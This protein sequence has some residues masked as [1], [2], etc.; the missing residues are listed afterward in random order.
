MT[1]FYGDFDK[2]KQEAESLKTFATALELGVN[3]MD[4]AWI[5]QSAGPDGKTYYNEE[6]VGKAIKIHGRDKFIICTKFGISA[7]RGVSDTL[8]SFNL[9]SLR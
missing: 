9:C 4:T 5:Y 1:A 8:I 3:L 2:D 7:T 6:L